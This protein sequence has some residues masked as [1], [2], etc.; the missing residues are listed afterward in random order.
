MAMNE[1]EVEAV[2]DTV[3][4][5]TTMSGQFYQKMSGQAR[6]PEETCVVI[7]NAEDGTSME[8]VQVGVQVWLGAYEG[9]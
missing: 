2:V 4:E 7:C 8:A 1:V 5:A 6:K 3:A 9:R